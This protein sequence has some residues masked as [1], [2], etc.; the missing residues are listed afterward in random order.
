LDEIG[1]SDFLA[2]IDSLAHAYAI[3]EHVDHVLAAL[4]DP[5]RRAILERVRQG[6]FSVAEIAAG[7]KKISRPAVSQHLRVLEAAELVWCEARGRQRFY[8]LDVRGLR[9]L[10]AYLDTFWDD[11]LG[12]Y[13]AASHREAA[14]QR[15]G[16]RGS[17]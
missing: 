8:R 17:R 11:V 15:A 10:R 3:M 5:T 2:R 7:F 1:N 13:E 14:R 16:R 9:L 4:G 12:A 6:P